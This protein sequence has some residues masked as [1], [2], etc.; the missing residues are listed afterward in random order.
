M[1]EF[2]LEA[3]KGLL[4]VLRGEGRSGREE[5]YRFVTLWVSLRRGVVVSLAASCMPGAEFCV[6]SMEKSVDM[7]DWVGWSMVGWR[8]R[9]WKAGTQQVLNGD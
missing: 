7:V 9:K 4:V 2:G 6:S 8:Q 5:K 1:H 3:G